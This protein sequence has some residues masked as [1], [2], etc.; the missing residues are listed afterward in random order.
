MSFTALTYPQKNAQGKAISKHPVDTQANCSTKEEFFQPYPIKL[1][2]RSAHPPLRDIGAADRKMLPA[3]PGNMRSTGKLQ[4]WRREVRCKASISH[5]AKSN[6]E[7]RKQTFFRL[8]PTQ[9]FH[10]D[11]IPAFT[12]K[13]NSLANWTAFMATLAHTYLT[14]NHHKVHALQPVPSKSEV[15]TPIYKSCSWRKNS[16]RQCRNKNQV[17]LSRSRCTVTHIRTEPAIPN[18]HEF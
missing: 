16:W 15:L 10:P 13:R 4:V 8:C 7:Q 11:T 3:W 18:N 17:M 6:C 14:H 2:A 9:P 12:V 5:W 1:R